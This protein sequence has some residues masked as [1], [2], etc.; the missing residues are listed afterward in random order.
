[1]GRG[2]NANPLICQRQSYFFY[3]R[4]VADYILPLPMLRG[5]Q[6]RGPDAFA[7]LHYHCSLHFTEFTG[8]R[9]PSVVVVQQVCHELVYRVASI[10]QFYF[11]FYGCLSAVRLTWLVDTES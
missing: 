10:G 7:H 3:V 9:C 5:V 11:A 4:R 8:H 1:M 6:K 2:L